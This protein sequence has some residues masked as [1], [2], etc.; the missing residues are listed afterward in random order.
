MTRF[1]ALVW[2]GSLGCIHGLILYLQITSP[3]ACLTSG[4]CLTMV[5]ISMISTGSRFYY[6]LLI[7]GIVDLIA[8]VTVLTS[9]WW[10][11]FAMQIQEKYEYRG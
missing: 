11:P 2:G 7:T 10:L 1:S 6:P 5:D 9:T 8:L 4:P 3:V